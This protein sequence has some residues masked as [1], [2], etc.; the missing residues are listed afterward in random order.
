MNQTVIYIL[1]EGGTCDHESGAC[2]CEKGWQ[3][4]LYVEND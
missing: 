3:G 1:F 4:A 2:T